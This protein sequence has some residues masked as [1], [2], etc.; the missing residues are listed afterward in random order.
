MAEIKE[1]KKYEFIARAIKSAEEILKENKSC[2]PARISD[3]TNGEL[4][5]ADMED[6]EFK[7]LSLK[8]IEKATIHCGKGNPHKDPD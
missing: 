5:L 8:H 4:I 1:P 2:S 3:I 7:E 6:S